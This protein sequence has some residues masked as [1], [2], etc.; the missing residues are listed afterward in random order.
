MRIALD[1]T[2]AITEP[3]GIG[4]YTR[5]LARALAHLGLEPGTLTFFNSE[6]L[7]SDQPAYELAPGRVLVRPIGHRNLTR[8]WHRLHIP[9]PAELLT[10]ACDL[11]HGPDFV[12]PPALFAQRVVT[13]HDLAYMRYP[14]A[15][16]PESLPISP[17]KYRARFEPPI[18]SLPFQM[19]LPATC[20]ISSPF[21][22]AK[23]A[24]STPA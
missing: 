7:P 2:S 24:S 21:L 6:P 19:P 10:G 23:S 14:E 17:P 20:P 3:A 1:Y 4:R 13:I 9:L 12:L 18:I 8:L 5:G 15:A 22:L 11:I 16:Q